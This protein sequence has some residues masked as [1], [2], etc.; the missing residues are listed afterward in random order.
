MFINLQK[1]NIQE[2]GYVCQKANKAYS[3]SCAI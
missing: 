1:S 3:V 2:I